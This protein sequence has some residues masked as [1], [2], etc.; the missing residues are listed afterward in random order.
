MGH[1]RKDKL[2]DNWSTDPFLDT[3]IFRNQEAIYDASR[4]EHWNRFLL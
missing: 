2:K 4:C 1:V 3:P